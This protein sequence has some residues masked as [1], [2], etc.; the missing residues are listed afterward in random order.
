MTDPRWRLPGATLVSVPI[1]P[2]T[3][4]SKAC[5]KLNRA[6]FSTAPTKNVKD[7]P[8]MLRRSK[9]WARLPTR[10][11][12]SSCQVT[13]ESA[14]IVVNCVNLPE[15]WKRVRRHHSPQILVMTSFPPMAATR[16]Y[17]GPCPR[18]RMISNSC[19]RPGIKSWIFFLIPMQVRRLIGT[20]GSLRNFSS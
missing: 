16:Y 7:A 6:R 5:S 13:K 19:G 1:R 8:E 4:P 3:T 18:I 11:K 9:V 2:N 10:R 20:A 15:I 12:S 14:F 17:I